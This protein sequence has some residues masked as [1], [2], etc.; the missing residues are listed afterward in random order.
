MNSNEVWL[1]AL[2]IG[3]LLLLRVFLR[4]ARSKGKRGESLVNAGIERY[5]DQGDYR[6]IKDVTLPVG[7]GTT[8]IDHVVVSTHGVFVIET[9]NM[10]GWIFGDPYQAQWTQQIYRQKYRFRNPLRQNHKHVKAVRET[11]GLGEHQ[12]FNVIVFV[13]HCTLK[14]QMPSEVVNGVVALSEF[15]KS[16]RVPVLAE[17]ELPDL[18]GRISERRLEPGRRTDRLHIRNVKKREPRFSVNADRCPRCG[19]KMVERTNRRSG[20][21]FLGCRRYPGCRGTR[22]LPQL[23]VRS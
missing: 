3:L 23:K 5:L 20:E 15:I 9:K 13:G 14:T 17:H 11:L 19:T 2:A 10:K 21:R 4:S 1:I 22:P 7:D 8:Q 12:V 18:V 6:L 16:K